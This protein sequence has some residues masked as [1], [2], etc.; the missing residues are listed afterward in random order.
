MKSLENKRFFAI[1]I[2]PEKALVKALVKACAAAGLMVPES[3][4]P[5]AI[6]SAKK[7]P[8]MPGSSVWRSSRR[9]VRR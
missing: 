1:S 9:E 6:G 4:V 7:D 8:G 5:V 3:P 2:D